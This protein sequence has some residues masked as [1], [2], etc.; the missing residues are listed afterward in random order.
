VLPAASAGSLDLLREV[1]H[2]VDQ[3]RGVQQGQV[4]VTRSRHL[5]HGGRSGRPQRRRRGSVPEE[6]S[7]HASGPHNIYDGIDLACYGA[8]GGLEHD[9]VVALGAD[10]NDV[11][12]RLRAGNGPH[13]SPTGDLVVELEAGD[14]RLTR[15]VA[16]QRVGGDRQ[17]VTGRFVLERDGRGASLWVP[18]IPA[19]RWS[20][21]LYSHTP[22]TSPALTQTLQP[23][24]RSTRREA[25]TSLRVPMGRV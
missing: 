1:E 20:S 21:T 24:W 23:V 22:P 4:V 14:V 16:Y 8:A 18:T 6:R 5:D 13:L 7:S 15:P 2:R 17:R 25:P 10:V 3:L 11:S 9:L 12:F 19:A